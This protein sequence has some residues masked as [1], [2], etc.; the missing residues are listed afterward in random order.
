MFVCITKVYTGFLLRICM[1]ISIENHIISKRVEMLLVVEHISG[2]PT[3]ALAILPC[4][5]RRPLGRILIVF[6]REYG[7]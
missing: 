3:E 7:E 4:C 1:S 2:G 5:L 6:T